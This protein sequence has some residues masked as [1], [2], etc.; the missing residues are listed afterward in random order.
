MVEAAR[1]L[2][3]F[4]PLKGYSAPGE[5]TGKSIDALLGLLC[6]TL[7]RLDE[8]EVH[9]ESALSFC[10]RAGYRPELAW[11][12]CDFAEALIQRNARHDR[13]RAEEL[14]GEGLALVKEMGMQPLEKKIRD[15]LRRIK[16]KHEK[17]SAYPAGLTEREVEVLKLAA[18]GLNNREIGER[19]FISPHTVAKHIQN[20]L[21]KTGMANRTEATAFAMREGLID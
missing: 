17:G 7:G 19:L 12:C 20:L 13:R 11:T 2:E 6:V 3:Y 4:L 16:D 5:P 21:E 14:L 8:A 1:Y 10:R 9:F 18:G 15:S